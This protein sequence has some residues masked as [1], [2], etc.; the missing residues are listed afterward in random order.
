MCQYALE[1]GDSG[2]NYSCYFQITLQ[3]S[4]G[5]I[6]HQ[7]PPTSWERKHL[8]SM[9]S[10]L[11]TPQASQIWLLSLLIPLCPLFLPSFPFFLPHFSSFSSLSLF[12]FSFLLFS[13]PVE[14]F[15]QHLAVMCSLNARAKG[16]AMPKQTYTSMLTFPKPF[17][18]MVFWFFRVFLLLVGVLFCFCFL[19][20]GECCSAV[21][22]ILH[23]KKF[24]IFSIW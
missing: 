22:D 14:I 24:S 9:G 8:L 1:R 12:C 21:L 5:G 13:V 4:S 16:I 19:P 10:K 15:P 23:V 17:P 7:R 11:D 3:T 6:R 18:L 20:E 2:V